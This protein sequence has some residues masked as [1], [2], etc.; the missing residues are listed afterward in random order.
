MAVRVRL[1]DGLDATA[2]DQALKAIV[3]AGVRW[4]AHGCVSLRESSVIVA[5]SPD[6]DAASHLYPGSEAEAI[7]EAARQLNDAILEALATPTG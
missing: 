6:L 3:D 7:Q 1:G 2:Y 4:K 5:I